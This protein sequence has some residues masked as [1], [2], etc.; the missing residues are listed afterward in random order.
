MNDTEIYLKLVPEPYSYLSMTTLPHTIGGVGNKLV[1]LCGVSF[2]AESGGAYLKGI[3]GGRGGGVLMGSP[4]LLVCRA[5][6]FLV[7]A[8]YISIKYPKY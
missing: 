3:L 6:I 1:K 5:N 7:T 8:S 2:I 4:I